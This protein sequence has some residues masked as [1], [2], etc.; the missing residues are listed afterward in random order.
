MNEKKTAAYDRQAAIRQLLGNLDQTLAAARKHFK[1]YG[2]REVVEKTIT[3]D[4]S[5]KTERTETWSWLD[6]QGEMRAMEKLLAELSSGGDDD[7]DTERRLF[8]TWLIE[9]ALE[10]KNGL[11]IDPSPAK[12]DSTE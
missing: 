6:I 3:Q 7:E 10:S 1:E 11:G 12:S 2:A 8:P 4:G 9:R 5:K